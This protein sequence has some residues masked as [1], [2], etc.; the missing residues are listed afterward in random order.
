MAKVNLGVRAKATLESHNLYL[1]LKRHPAYK[2]VRIEPIVTRLIANGYALAPD[3]IIR[4]LN[5][6]LAILDA[7]EGAILTSTHSKTVL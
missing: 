3:G 1:M 5:A 7:V 2:M 4:T 6:L